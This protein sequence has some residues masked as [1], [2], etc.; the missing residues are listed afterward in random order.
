MFRVKEIELGNSAASS[1]VPEPPQ[2]EMKVDVLGC[3]RA[4]HVPKDSAFLPVFEAVVNAIHSTQDRFGTDVLAQGRIEV[5]VVRVPQPDLP[6][7]PG[8]PSVLPIERVVVTD[9]GQGFTPRNLGSFQTAYTTAKLD[10]GGKGVGRFSWLAVFREAHVESTYHEE[11]GPRRRSFTFRPTPRGIEGHTDLPVEPEAEL[12]TAVE[13]RGIQPKYADALR[14]GTDVIAEKIFEHCFPYFVVGDCPEVL[15]V[16]VLPDGAERVLVNDK[17]KELRIG[18]PQPLKVGSHVLEARHVQQ[19][20]RGER[21]HTAHLCANKREVETF[22]LSAVTELGDGPIASSDGQSLVHH[23]FVSGGALDEAV[24]SVRTRLVLAEDD[25][26]FASAGELDMKSIKAAAGEQVRTE[27]AGFLEDEKKTNFERIER[28]IRTVQPEYR[29]LLTRKPDELSR[30]RWT[31]NPRQL[32][33][34]LYKVQQAWD[35][36]ARARLAAVEEKVLEGTNPELFA[37]ELGRVSAEVNEAGEASLIK[38]VVRRRA[39]LK[40]VRALLGRNALEAHIH[41][42][43][44][45]PKKTADDVEYGDHNLWLVDDTFSFYEHVASDLP[46]SAISA[47]PVDGLRRPDLLAFK[48]GDSPYQHVALLELKRPERGNDN[49]AQQLMDYAVLLREGGAKNVH[50]MTMPGIPKSVRIDGVA[51]V[52][53]G[54]EMERRLRTGPGNL[55]KA[56]GEW[57]WYGFVPEENLSIEVLDFQAFVVR[58]EQRNRAFFAKL[59]LS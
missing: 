16:D 51:L 12:T 17:V 39:I 13:L 44:F 48:T 14:R 29:H 35:T 24:N 34:N 9:N 50:H 38:Y 18:P 46:F 8:R 43:L 41:Q 31:D 40:V 42:I 45:P 20:H 5:R 58:A 23:V 22:K 49:P 55:R 7:S 27:L 32:D 30:V 36:E 47:A 10:R 15:L 37:D 28:H 19:Q 57:R 25:S 1:P 56:D 2:P 21:Q 11:S 3:V 6:G 53:L 26:L 54:P 59:G 4:T 33:E 52:T